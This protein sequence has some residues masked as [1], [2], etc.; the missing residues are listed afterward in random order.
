MEVGRFKKNVGNL[1]IGEI[2]HALKYNFIHKFMI[3]IKKNE[4]II[5]WWTQSLLFFFNAITD[6]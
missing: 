2:L 4:L 1:G 3:L 6:C 5:C